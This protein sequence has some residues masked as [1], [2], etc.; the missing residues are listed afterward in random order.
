MEAGD[1][2]D[3]PK[4][5]R[6]EDQRALRVPVALDDPY[7]EVH[8]RL[9]ILMCTA[10]VGEVIQWQVAGSDPEVE[11]LPFG[12]LSDANPA[13]KVGAIILMEGVAIDTAEPTVGVRQ[14]LQPG[15]CPKLCI[16]AVTWH[17]VPTYSLLSPTP[18]CVS[19]CTNGGVQVGVGK[20]PVPLPRGSQPEQTSERASHHRCHRHSHPCRPPCRP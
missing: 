10:A 2:T 20:R 19:R 17:K 1:P 11:P 4:D 13:I 5:A 3:S 14:P 16:S 6:L 12:V 8:Q 15:L 7:P 9:Q 18:T